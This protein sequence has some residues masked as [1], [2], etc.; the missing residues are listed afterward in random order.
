MNI[1]LFFLGIFCALAGGCPP[2]FNDFRNL[3][4]A[5]RLAEAIAE[6]RADP[7]LG[8]ETPIGGPNRAI[9]PWPTNNNGLVYIPFCYAAGY[10][11]QKNAVAFEKG[12]GL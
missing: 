2:P 10:V 3:H 6:Y 1:F 8:W 7:Q 12:W 9:Q 4:N 11:R 5:T